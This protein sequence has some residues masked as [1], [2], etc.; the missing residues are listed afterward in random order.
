MTTPPAVQLS[1]ISRSYETDNGSVLAVEDVDLHADP[2]EW[3]TLIGPSGCGKSTLFN[4]VAGLDQP[5]SGE[6][7]IGG[8]VLDDR[9]GASAYL[10]Q[11]DA[12]LPWRRVVD[13]VTLPLELAGRPRREARRVAEPLLDRFGLSAFAGSWPWQL[14]GGMRQRVAVLRTIVTRP[15]LLLLDEPFGALDGITR[16][17]LQQW[18]GGVLADDGATVLLVTHDVTEAVFLSDRVVVMSPRP[19]RVVAEITVDLPRPRRVEVQE[20]PAFVELEGRLRHELRAATW[21]AA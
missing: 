10:P 2:G 18:V 19:G 17:D 12:L 21:P 13:N 6:I 11:R 16:T 4:L 15:R 1:R 5:S 20:T 9:L 8:S 14:S 7:R 3:V